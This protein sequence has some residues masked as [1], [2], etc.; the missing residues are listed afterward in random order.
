MHVGR[1]VANQSTETIAMLATNLVPLRRWRELASVSEEAHISER[2]FMGWSQGRLS[3]SERSLQ[4]I[5]LL[6]TCTRWMLLR[7]ASG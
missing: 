4:L 6:T 1:K 3:L 5:E 7:R 2:L